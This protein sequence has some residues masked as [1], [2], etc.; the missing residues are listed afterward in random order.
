VSV[1]VLGKVENTRR[2][3]GSEKGFLV[4]GADWGRFDSF[5]ETLD[6]VLCLLDVRFGGES[7][8][9]GE[10]GAEEGSAASRVTMTGDTSSG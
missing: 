3:T 9:T 8:S 7:S 10:E 1:D 6:L 5:E 4:G 2:L